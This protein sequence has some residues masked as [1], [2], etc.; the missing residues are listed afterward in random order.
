MINYLKLTGLLRIQLFD[1]SYTSINM[2]LNSNNTSHKY[3]FFIYLNTYIKIIGKH[4][5]VR[6]RM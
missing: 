5:Q 4:K 3:F 2:R 6:F 1:I